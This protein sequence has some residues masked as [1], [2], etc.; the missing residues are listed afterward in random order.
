M[1]LLAWIRNRYPAIRR[2]LISTEVSYSL[3]TRAVNRAAIDYFVPLPWN[4]GELPSMVD[5]LLFS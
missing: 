1:E 5:E 3:M 2:V 4:L